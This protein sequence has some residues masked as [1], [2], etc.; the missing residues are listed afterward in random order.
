MLLT[1][2]RPCEVFALENDRVD[3]EKKFIRIERNRIRIVFPLLT[4]VA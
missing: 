2:L 1:G 3:F 4:L